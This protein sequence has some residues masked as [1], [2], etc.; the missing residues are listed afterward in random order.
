MS[1][2]FGSRE[3]LKSPIWQAFLSTC[4]FWTTEPFYLLCNPPPCQL[5]TV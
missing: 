4:V 5:V 3:P 2:D 1:F